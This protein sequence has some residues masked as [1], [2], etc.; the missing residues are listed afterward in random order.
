VRPPDLR[1]C[2]MRLL[3]CH[4]NKDTIAVIRLCSEFA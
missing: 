1:P 4:T 2:Q 3:Q